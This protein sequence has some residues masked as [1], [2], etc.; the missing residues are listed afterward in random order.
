MG[1]IGVGVGGV[2]PLPAGTGGGLWYYSPQSG[3]RNFPKKLTFPR[4]NDLINSHNFIF[5]KK[6]TFPRLSI[7]LRFLSNF[8]PKKNDVFLCPP[9]LTSKRQAEKIFPENFQILFTLLKNNF[10]FYFFCFINENPKK[11]FPE[12]FQK[13]SGSL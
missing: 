3:V 5:P 11:I 9:L 13:F 4:L 6:L 10:Q 1:H 7:F 12:N 8:I 2:N